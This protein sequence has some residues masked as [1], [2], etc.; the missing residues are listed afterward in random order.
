MPGVAR[1]R[2][3][4]VE[5]IRKIDFSSGAILV[6]IVQSK[7]SLSIGRPY[8]EILYTE[9][10]ADIK[11]LGVSKRNWSKALSSTFK[12]IQAQQDIFVEIFKE[13]GMS[14]GRGMYPGGPGYGPGEMDG[15]EGMRRMDA[16]DEF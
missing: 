16:Y 1:V 6:D 11:H 4:T 14:T 3:K 7:R 2:K 15:F 13:R 10:G 9:N 8:Q 12:D 5:D